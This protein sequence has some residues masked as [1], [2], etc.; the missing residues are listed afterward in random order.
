MEAD[1]KDS[2]RDRLQRSNPGAHRVLFSHDKPYPAVREVAIGALLVLAV[3]GT[4]WGYTGQPLNRS[5][6]VVVESGS[7]MH[8]T[9]GFVP[10]GRDCQPTH[11]GRLGAIDPGD[12]ILVQDVD[13]ASDV[14]TLVQSGHHHYGRSGDVIVYRPDGQSVRT[15]IIHRA[16]FWLTINSDGTFSVA[17]L[18]LDHVSNLDQPVLRDLGLHGGYADT[19]R[20]VHAT[21][22]DSGFVT[23]GDNNGE[24][25]Q[26]TLTTF[27][28]KTAWVMGKARGE[29]PWLGLVKLLFSDT[30]Q[31]TQ[32]YHNAGDD[33]KTMLVVTLA[34]LFG[35]PSLSE[36]VCAARR[37]AA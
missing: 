30:M 34:V 6:V 32:N 24:A 11:Y 22:A 37:E 35:G 18:G 9:N 14:T 33:S 10:Y 2:W 36:P 17:E 12:L 25:D 5:P 26:G 19:L 23:R 16:L 21:P 4:L 13:R 7:M 31:H 3:L 29:I 27:P 15:P 20:H 28:V 8:C 1:G